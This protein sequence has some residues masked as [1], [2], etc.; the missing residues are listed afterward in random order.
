M[1]HT[2]R[3]GQP[4][5]LNDLLVN[6]ITGALGQCIAIDAGGIR[7]QSGKHCWPVDREQLAH[8][9]C[10]WIRMADKVLHNSADA[11]CNAAP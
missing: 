10:G 1:T 9:R 5:A 8:T 6:R 11:S 3:S 4:V 2:D 7:V